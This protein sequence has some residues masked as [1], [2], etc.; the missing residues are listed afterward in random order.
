MA[1]NKKTILC[2]IFIFLI[3]LFIRGNIVFAHG[4][5]IGIK[6][7]VDNTI[8][9]LYLT[10]YPTVMFNY[11]RHGIYE[12]LDPFLKSISYKFYLQDNPPFFYLVVG[13]LANLIAPFTK[14]VNSG[15]LAVAIVYSL[16][17]V[18]IFLFLKAI[19]KNNI[20]SFLSSLTLALNVA[21]LS[22]LF[23][24]DWALIV[25]SVLFFLTALLTVRF[26][27]NQSTK[28]FLSATAA[29]FLM[30]INYV[31]YLAVHM[32][33]IPFYSMA[34]AERKRVLIG[35]SKITLL[36]FVISL[37]LL[38]NFI[39]SYVIDEGIARP[40]ETYL[41]EIQK[42]TTLSAPLLAFLLAGSIAFILSVIKK[43]KIKE[44]LQTLAP[45]IG[46]AIS[47]LIGDLIFH[48]SSYPNRIFSSNLAV[49]LSILLC[50]SLYIFREYFSKSGTLHARLGAIEILLPL[51][52]LLIMVF[53]N[54]NRNSYFMNQ[55]S[56][57]ILLTASP[58]LT[59]SK[60]DALIW[61]RKNTEKNS[62]VYFIGFFSGWR[63]LSYRVSYEIPIQKTQ[64]KVDFQIDFITPLSNDYIVVS[65]KIS[66][67]TEK[68]IE[69][70]I[71]VFKRAGL[72][73]IYSNR[74][75]VIFRSRQSDRE[76]VKAIMLEIV[77]QIRPKQ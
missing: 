42:A 37:P 11:D 76:Q 2:L 15:F 55:E 49:I 28:N 36:T 67:E 35:L 16:L 10:Q 56:Q 58:I 73:V 59:D 65:P 6:D 9:M 46:I 64:R 71:Q 61:L 25:G 38:I 74:D 52:I 54:L 51:C 50:Y 47:F 23:N 44:S 32:L 60:Y 5:P 21:T 70:S 17:P 22:H 39:N 13:S 41:L 24:G 1:I 30:T 34:S 77:K 63:A 3:A 72:P 68:N 62:T 53:S 20:T 57:S 33:A 14:D 26:I 48:L 12:K 40:T 27:E 4:Y 18:I 19:T 31:P 8:N 29:T 43:F 75:V 66:G 7:S 45:L 69:A